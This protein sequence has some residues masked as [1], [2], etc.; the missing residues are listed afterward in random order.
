MITGS[1]GIELIKE[2]ESFRDLAYQDEAGVW[3]IGYGTTV[4]NG[5]PVYKGQRCSLQ[6]ALEW[7]QKDVIKFEKHVTRLI[8]KPLLQNEFDA[9]V[10]FTYNVGEGALEKSTLRVKIN[11][12]VP[13]LERNFTDWNK[14]EIK[15]KLVPSAGLTRRRKSE[16]TLFRF[17]RVQFHF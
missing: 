17:G 7:L 10:C 14:I 12:G 11:C 4:I 3:T 8:T 1:Q 16:Y 2:Y 15:G 13:V 5:H 9:L 6:E